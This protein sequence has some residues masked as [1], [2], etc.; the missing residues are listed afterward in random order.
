MIDRFHVAKLYRKGLD[1]LR[2]Q[3]LQ[4]L[5]QELSEEEYKQLPGVMWALRKREDHLTDEDKDL[6]ARL[7]IH[8]PLLKVAY[9][10]CNALTGIFDQRIGKH[11]AK[12]QL[13]NWIA[14]VRDS[15][16]HCCNTFV[17]T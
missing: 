11:S 2:K 17:T 6:L 12:S 10:L 14:R 3:E 13:T 9:E 5:K 4:R 15:T 1:T 8:A 7:F 16:L